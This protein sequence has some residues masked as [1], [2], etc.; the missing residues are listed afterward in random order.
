MNVSAGISLAG[1]FN[2]PAVGVAPYFAK[3]SFEL[4]MPPIAFAKLPR[5]IARNVV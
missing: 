4:R 3:Y 2:N 5:A 1:L